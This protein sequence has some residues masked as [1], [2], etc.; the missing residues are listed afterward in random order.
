MQIEV[1]AVMAR[2][3]DD[4][5]WNALGTNPTEAGAWSVAAEA[6]DAINLSYSISPDRIR[7]AALEMCQSIRVVP[8]TLVFDE[9]ALNA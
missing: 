6:V 2:H 3:P 5:R 4:G 7:R 1:W 9:D 8:A